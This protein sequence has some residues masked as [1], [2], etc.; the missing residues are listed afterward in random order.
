MSLENGPR[1]FAWCD[2]ERRKV[3]PQT[4]VTIRTF[5]RDSDG[6]VAFRDSSWQVRE[7]YHAL[8]DINV[9]PI[10]A[11]V[12]ADVEFYAGD[13][14]SDVP[15]D[16][17]SDV[18]SSCESVAED[19]P[20]DDVMTTAEETSASVPAPV[21]HQAGDAALPPVSNE[22]DAVRDARA[23]PPLEAIPVEPAER[24][25]DDAAF[26]TLAALPMPLR[27]NVL[28]SVAGLRC[29]CGGDS[30]G[31]GRHLDICPLTMKFWIV[32]KVVVKT[33][34][35]P[36]AYAPA[37]SGTD[38]YNR[39]RRHIAR[40]GC[41]AYL[42]SLS[43]PGVSHQSRPSVYDE[44]TGR[45]QT[46]VLPRTSEHQGPPV[47]A[48]DLDAR[49]DG[50]G[51]TRVAPCSDALPLLE[52]V[53]SVNVSILE[54]VPKKARAAVDKSLSLVFHRMSDYVRYDD[55]VRYA[56]FARLVLRKPRPNEG[57][58]A[59]IVAERARRF[60][61]NN[62]GN[63]STMWRELLEEIVQRRA[64]YEAA[65]AAAPPPRAAP[66]TA[67]MADAAATQV[68]PVAEPNETTRPGADTLFDGVMDIDELEKDTGR[69]RKSISYARRC[70]FSKSMACFTS[71]AA[72]EK[73]AENAERL[74][75]LHPAEP[76]PPPR[77]PPAGAGAPGFGK[78]KVRGALRSFKLAS[79]GGL[80]LLT[81]QHLKDCCGVPGTFVLEALHKVV[82]AIAGGLIPE[83]VR[84]LICG[85]RLVGLVK[86][87]GRSLRPVASGDV[88]R[89]LA[90]RLLSKS[91]A[92]YARNFFLARKQVGVAVEGGADAAIIACRDVARTLPAGH[93]IFKVDQRNAFNAGS[94][95]AIL[96]LV[97]R[98]FPTLYPYAR[99]AYGGHTWLY[100]GSHRIISQ[101]GVQQGCPLG[102]LFFSLLMAEAR[103]L[104]IQ[105]AAERHPELTPLDFEAWYL[106]DG[107]VAGPTDAVIAYIEALEEVCASFNL[108]F[109]RGK[110]EVISNNGEPLPDFFADTI[111]RSVDDFELL[112]VPCGNDESAVRT[113]SNL[114][115]KVERRV[116]CV[117]QLADPQVVYALLRHCG[118]FPLSNFLARAVGPLGRDAFAR[119]D[120]AVLTAFQE[121]VTDICDPIARKA[122]CLPAGKGG[123]GLR[124]AEDS[125]PLAFVGAVVAAR[126]LRHHLVTPVCAERLDAAPDPRID[127]ALEA[128]EIANAAAVRDLAHDLICHNP[129]TEGELRALKQQRALQGRRDAFNAANILEC[130]SQELRT[131]LLSAST[132]FASS[133]LCPQP[134]SEDPMW[135]DA[136]IFVS[137]IRHRYGARL[138]PDFSDCLLCGAK[139]ACDPF[140]S[141]TMKCLGT[142]AKWYV[143][144]IV[145]DTIIGLAAEAL[146]SPAAEPTNALTTTT[147]RPDVILKLHAGVV[148][149][150]AC[151]DV[152]VASAETNA[153]RVAASREA[154]AA[155]LHAQRDKHAIY[156]D[157]AEQEGFAFIGAAFDC[158]GATSPDAVAL[159]KYIAVA[160]GRRMNLSSPRAIPL[161]ATIVMT[162]LM[163]SI[164]RLLL[165]NS[166]PTARARDYIAFDD[167]MEQ[168]AVGRIPALRGGHD[169]AGLPL[170]PQPCPPDDAEEQAAECPTHVTLDIGGVDDTCDMTRVSPEGLAATE[171]LPGGAAPCTSE[172]E[173]HPCAPTVNRGDVEVS[174][175]DPDVSRNTN[176]M[177]VV[178][179]LPC[180]NDSTPPA[181]GLS[182]GPSQDPDE[183]GLAAP[184]LPS[185]GPYPLPSRPS[186]RDGVDQNIPP[187]TPS[188]AARLTR[189]ILSSP[190]HIVRTNEPQM[191]LA[192]PSASRRAQTGRS[193]TVASFALVDG[194][195]AD[196][197]GAVGAAVLTASRSLRLGQR[198]AAAQRGST[199]VGVAGG[200]PGLVRPENT[201]RTTARAQLASAGSSSAVIAGHGA[202][203]L[204]DSRSL[205]SRL[206]GQ[207]DQLV[208]D[209]QLPSLGPGAVLRQGPQAASC[210]P[211]P[212]D[213]R[214]Q[215][216]MPL[217]SS[218]PQPPSHPSQHQLR[219][220]SDPVSSLAPP[221]PAQV[222]NAEVA[223]QLPLLQRAPSLPASTA[224]SSNRRHSVQPRH[225]DDDVSDAA[226]AVPTSVHHP[227][228][229]TVDPQLQQ[230][231]P[232]EQLP[233][234]M[235]PSSLVRSSHISSSSSASPADVCS[236]RAPLSAVR[237]PADAVVVSSGSSGGAVAVHVGI[238]DA[239][240]VDAGSSARP[241]PPPCPQRQAHRAPPSSGLADS[242]SAQQPHPS[243]PTP[244][245]LQQQPL[246]EHSRPPLQR[247]RQEDHPPT[248]HLQHSQG[249]EL[250]PSQP[251][252]SSVSTGSSRTTTA[253]AT[254]TGTA[255]T[256]T[257]SSPSTLSSR[258][259]SSSSVSSSSTSCATGRMDDGMSSSVSVPPAVHAALA[260]TLAAASSSV[261]AV[262]PVK[263]DARAARDEVRGGETTS[264]TTATSS[265]STRAT[266][267]SLLVA[268]LHGDALR[269]TSSSAP[270]RRC[271]V[272]AV[273][274]STSA[275]KSSLPSSSSSASTESPAATT[276]A[277]AAASTAAAV[278]TALAATSAATS[279]SAAR[280]PPSLSPSSQQ[281]SA[282]TAASTAAV[283]P[284]A[285]TITSS[286]TSTSTA[287]TSSRLG[288][289]RG[290]HLCGGGVDDH[291]FV[292]SDFAIQTSSAARAANLSTTT[293]AAAA[294]A[295]AA[296]T[297]ATR[298]C[299]SAVSSSTLVT[300]ERNKDKTKETRARSG[301]KQKK[302]K[303]N[304][305]K[306]GKRKK[307][308]QKV[309]QCQKGPVITTIDVPCV[310]VSRVADTSIQ[311]APRCHART[312][313]ES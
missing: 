14:G 210:L 30:R 241:P 180:D 153:I 242:I 244:P 312:G 190:I 261:C 311:L 133:W 254:V 235:V 281:S 218:L 231:Q 165:R 7:L 23:L 295:A 91:V 167:T 47:T 135:H 96:D 305:T 313:L 69:L 216:S 56:L 307:Y 250:R 279:S 238:L 246:L 9:H 266:S 44:R 258:L 70:E 217:I 158:F 296:A 94:R 127:A 186:E 55:F 171:Q 176:V 139:G 205:P 86:K 184:V 136:A 252:L 255:S 207:F 57:E 64:A 143:H 178:S 233:C 257:S 181:S 310:F 249:H 194:Q 251:S 111:Q 146:L 17:P 271:S 306:R 215:P 151:V 204:W 82:L 3:S 115:D 286:C 1:K 240:A 280:R 213:S 34:S 309:T 221:H 117:A 159:I 144:N 36:T 16:A 103:G 84:P 80:T 285:A 228:R 189:G 22:E 89:R 106:D 51:D 90:G 26:E 304:K 123:M 214:P 132:K 85:A 154:G 149:V 53:V 39:I 122:L 104:A 274:S 19:E 284:T 157:A 193:P 300:N 102:P 150:Y 298:P 156:A 18:T 126:A 278:T 28:A 195:A 116:M 29:I 160:L 208:R 225:D 113:C 219:G 54:N 191:D 92:P 287:A 199:S 61:S 303:H 66:R 74:R 234:G 52:D 152:T 142:G 177:P 262:R 128:P 63:V 125:A 118:G 202:A 220:V 13:S 48:G 88:L 32:R 299:T 99:M 141:H 297:A 148:P 40:C 223:S 129:P 172:A 105:R 112:G 243:L 301:K 95:A 134:G 256:T 114:A 224:D 302:Q 268:A 20:G 147:R 45:S 97:A 260:A 162:A 288:G 4:R 145:R 100:F 170:H 130:A 229:P 259:L 81:P 173:S 78:K 5:F 163:S 42:Q 76:I 237:S 67:E 269:T 83:E 37:E 183:A 43:V 110:C 75:A 68:D 11:V 212:L 282:P 283:V 6:D 60:S 15:I 93:V 248:N 206:P 290:E 294:A 188:D 35:S 41:E 209:I 49:G 10:E 72:A 59:R 270:G 275:A 124:S 289:R 264:T 201:S 169:A 58:L 263:D 168:Q 65:V 253:P 198:F 121:G 273:S 50:D 138:Q 291:H 25:P 182:Q 131:R 247:Q 79:S 200:A 140:G 203:G 196:P 292:P 107:T 185:T 71:A 46:L 222:S 24:P 108:Q 98:D 197:F 119:I 77:Q 161:T 293:T 109:N 308:R 12:L 73:S 174:T 62:F 232:S 166:A 175:C 155:A 120:K 245:V 272:V 164:G 192:C 265:T 187:V 227:L 31:S 137:L 33:S 226:V 179:S 230:Q 239:D 276:G 101:A 8:F 211:P 87:D 27:S 38:E 277:A 236:H 21:L 267:S 2:H